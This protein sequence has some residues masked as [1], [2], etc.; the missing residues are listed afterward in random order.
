MKKLTRLTTLLPLV[1][2]LLDASAGCKLTSGEATGPDAGAEGGV[3]GAGGS[4]Q[5]GS[6]GSGAGAG[7]SGQAGAAGQDGADPTEATRLAIDAALSAD[8]R[9]AQGTPLSPDDYEELAQLAAAVPGVEAV[10]YVGDTLGTIQIKIAD[11]GV[12]LW[13]HITDD[14]TEADTLPPDADVASLLSPDW[15]DGW[16]P[17]SG[18]PV[19]LPAPP[20]PISNSYADHFPLAGANPDPDYAEDDKVACPAE[21]KVAIV[22]FLWTE[23]HEQTSLYSEQ[24]MVD[25]VMLWD[26]VTRMA[27]A[28]GFQVDHFQ[29]ND[30]NTGNFNKLADYSIVITIGHG[31]RP[32]PSSAARLG[33]SLSDVLTADS[34]EHTKVMA[35]GITYEDGWKKGYLLR[36]VRTRGVWWTSLLFKDL[37][38]PAV[39][40]MWMPNECWAMLPFNVGLARDT[41]GKWAWES[42]VTGR[43]Y[44]IGDGL[45]DAGVKVV[46]GY[47]TPATPKAVLINTLPFF[48]RLFG[49]YY[50]KDKPP[51]PHT[52][53]P[54]C[55]SAQTYFRLPNT[56]QLALYGNKYR[57]GSMYTMYAVDPP[58]YLRKVCE[59]NPNAHAYMQSF[60]LQAGTP[61]T[62]LPLCWGSYWSKGEH[63]SGIQDPLCSQG[64][65]PTTEQATGDAACAVKIARKA[66]NALLAP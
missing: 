53:W 60:M 25:G 55:M 18:S 32:G 21:G 1:A 64:D 35:G 62:A 63:P 34:Y 27:Q 8:P 65:D 42:G 7:A 28:A 16:E 47:V 49:G 2:L 10:D 15:N 12:M 20:S 17:P 14:R 61:A 59:E 13:R 41:A 52:F 29:D 58:Q 11:G 26:K 36:N 33:K 3:S 4:G 66:T 23:A 6:G 54:T 43:V 48:R 19:G 44:N 57:A 56:P 51:A 39:P 30:I 40:Q 46:F 22:D 24:W 31:G 37:Y 50:A 5:A 38:K 45:M 9:T